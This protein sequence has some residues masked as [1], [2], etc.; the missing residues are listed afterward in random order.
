M[1]N[2]KKLLTIYAD[3]QTED[4]IYALRKR[5]EFCRMSRCQ[6]IRMLLESAL[7]EFESKKEGA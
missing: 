3:K 7:D 4:R 2:T 1:S 5:E 6:L